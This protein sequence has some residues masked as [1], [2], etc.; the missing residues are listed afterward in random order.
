MS[1]STSHLN[2][3]P[4]GAPEENGAAFASKPASTSGGRLVCLD[5]FRGFIMMMLISSGSLVSSI[6]SPGKVWCS[7]T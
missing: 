1:D 5:A 4:V 6:M 3:V 7:G 2:V